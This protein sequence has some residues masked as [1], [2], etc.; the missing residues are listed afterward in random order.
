MYVCYCAQVCNVH[1]AFPLHLRGD[2]TLVNSLICVLINLLM[3]FYLYDQKTGKE[4]NYALFRIIS[5]A[6][7][8]SK[9]TSV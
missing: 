5:S 9:N 4:R 7:S 1:T 8:E 6:V 2:A 3:L